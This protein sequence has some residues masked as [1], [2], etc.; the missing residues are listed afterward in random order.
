[1]QV[2]YSLENKG[3]TDEEDRR[4]VELGE[5]LAKMQHEWEAVGNYA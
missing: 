3:E 4:I 1:V 5:L 2:A